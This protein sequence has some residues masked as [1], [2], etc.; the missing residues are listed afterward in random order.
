MLEIN[1]KDNTSSFGFI[2]SHTESARKRESKENTQRYR[3]YKR[4]MVTY[5]SELH[6]KH[7]TNV[8]KSAYMLIRQT[9]LA[10]VPDLTEKLETL[11]TDN[12]AYFE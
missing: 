4:I 7:V 12:Y 1:G 11:F 8:D 5:F 3:I 6:F 2:G 10:K 9:E